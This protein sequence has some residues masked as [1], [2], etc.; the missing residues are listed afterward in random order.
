MCYT[1]SATKANRLYWLGRYVERVY[2]CLH[3]M[4]RCY[5]KMI[6]GPESEYESHLIKMD[7]DNIYSDMDSFRMGMMY[8]HNNPSSL[9]SGMISAND[10]AVMLRKDISS[11]T[12]S[13]IQL[14]LVHL[15]KCAEKKEKNI[16]N[17]QKVTDYLLAFWGS[18]DERI[19]DERLYNLMKIGRM[20]EYIDMHI[21]F[22]YPFERIE[23]AFKRLKEY[24]VSEA[25]IYDTMMFQKLENLL[26]AEKYNPKDTE[27]TNSVLR[28]LNHLVML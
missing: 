22:E 5:D 18:S 14:S 9:L 20:L 23:D 3:L 1:I 24:G 4:R 28:Y 6:D 2:I 15:Q 11:E 21:R 25:G 17:L 19:F 16:T 13:Y 12:L 8:D 7:S 10:N 27:Y 26:T